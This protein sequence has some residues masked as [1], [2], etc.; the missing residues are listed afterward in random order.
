MF[1]HTGGSRIIYSKEIVGIFHLPPETTDI[2]KEFIESA[3]S[4]IDGR[5]FKKNKS[6]VVT[7]DSV[8]LSPISPLTLARRSNFMTIKTAS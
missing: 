8:V 3:F 6:F 2:N 1:T 4:L 7:T 5:E